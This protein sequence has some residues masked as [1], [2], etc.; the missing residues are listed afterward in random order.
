VTETGK[1]PTFIITIDTEGDKAWSRPDGR[2]V[3]TENAR[4]LPRFQSLCERHAFKPTYLTNHEMAL[5]PFFIEFGRDLIR[6]GAGEIGMHLHAWDTPP[7]VPLTENDALFRPFLTEYAT[8]VMESKIAFMT[9]LLENRFAV[10]MTSHRAGRWAFDERYA[11]LLLKYG[12]TVDCSVTPG[13]SWRTSAGA[14]GGHG[15]T[16]YTHFPAHWYFIDLDDISR[17]GNSGLLELPMSVTRSPLHRICPRCYEL[18]PI[19]NMIQRF[20]PPIRWCRL[21]GKNREDVE[22]V[23]RQSIARKAPYLQWMQHSSELMP[24][25]S[26]YFG[27]ADAVERLYDDLEALFELVEKHFTGETLSACAERLAAGRIR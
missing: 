17:P 11:R 12:Y 10:K 13:A 24:G 3:E 7:I 20:G 2:R 18:G 19:A 15:G 25:G 26:P 1:R 22:K 14:P 9:G 27:D 16:D 4:F 6:R 8:D 23:I 21:I 5:D